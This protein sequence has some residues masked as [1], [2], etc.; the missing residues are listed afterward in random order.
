MKKDRGDE[1]KDERGSF[2]LSKTVYDCVAGDAGMLGVGFNSALETALRDHYVRDANK[3]RAS[4]IRKLGGWL[5]GMDDEDRK[6]LLRVGGALKTERNIRR[7]TSP[8][9]GRKRSQK[10]TA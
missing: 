9:G 7:R 6:L 8:A 3:R 1:P 4:E 5:R 10:E 2:R